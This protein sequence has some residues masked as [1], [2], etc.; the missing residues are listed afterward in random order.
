MSW[1]MMKS[2]LRLALLLIATNWAMNAAGG[3]DVSGFANQW[4][5]VPAENHW[6]P[7]SGLAAVVFDERMW[8]LGGNEG[9]GGAVLNDVWWSVYGASWTLANRRRRVV[10]G[11]GASGPR[12]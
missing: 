1:A 12:L 4:F 5:E 11:H 8:V 7:R 6:S 10:A 3:Q 9:S 2:V